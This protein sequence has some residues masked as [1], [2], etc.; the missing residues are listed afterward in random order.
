[1]P[2]TTN[3]GNSRKAPRD[4]SR[5]ASRLHKTLIAI[6]AI[7]VV[8]FGY[9]AVSGLFTP[10]QDKLNNRTRSSMAP[11]AVYL[12]TKPS[13]EGSV[14][15]VSGDISLYGTTKDYDNDGRL[16]GVLYALNQEGNKI[17]SALVRFGPDSSSVTYT[18]FRVVK[19]NIEY[20]LI[21]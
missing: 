6:F 16:E 5:L 2:F 8:Y 21:D 19:G 9:Y 3:I 7:G 20:F 12:I 10:S 18:R 17:D 13:I 14:G 15:G 4:I 11:H 1:M